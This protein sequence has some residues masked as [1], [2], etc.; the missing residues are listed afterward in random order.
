[1]I[2]LVVF[3]V[4]F[5]VGV[6]ACGKGQK[7]PSLPPPLAETDATSPPAE[8]PPPQPSPE[9]SPPSDTEPQPSEPPEEPSTPPTPPPTEE[10]NPPTAVFPGEPWNGET[11]VFF[12]VIGSD[13]RNELTGNCYV[14]GARADSVHIISLSPITGKG[15]VLNIPRDA[16]VNIPG[17]GKDRINASLALGGSVLVRKTVEGLTGLTIHYTAVTTFCGFIELVNRLGGINVYVPRDIQ[18]HY[19]IFWKKCST[20]LWISRRALLLKKGWHKGSSALNGCEALYFSRSRHAFAG[21]DFDR[22]TNQGAVLIAGLKKFQELAQTPRG[23]TNFIT[24]I[25]GIQ[26]LQDTVQF[27]VSREELLRLGHLAR[28]IKPDALENYTL[29][30]NGCWAGSANVV[31]LSSS[32]NDSTDALFRDIRTDAELNGK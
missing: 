13:G 6:S 19:A 32:N 9:T 14:Q 27:F 15:T 24:Y 18:D 25:Q 20:K 23:F 11:P 10:N 7:E 29:R 4:A 5:V 8:P 21:G 16:W 17:H 31:C 30:G 2:V 12:L 28:T 26:I 3:L 22:A 1:M